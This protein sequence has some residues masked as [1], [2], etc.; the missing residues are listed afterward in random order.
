MRR[1]L[2][3]SACLIGSAVRYDGTDRRFD[4]VAEVLARRYELVA[5]CPEVELGLGVP[6]ETIQ[7]EGDPERPRLFGSITR[8]DL[9]E[10]MTRWAVR[11]AAR[12]RLSNLVGYVWK[13]RSPSCGPREVKHWRGDQRNRSAAGSSFA[14]FAR[15]APS[16]RWRTSES[17]RAPRPRPRSFARST[18][19]RASW[20]LAP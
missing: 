1:P 3:V 19:G 9:T 11:R 15:P 18:S 17:S 12:L 6:R 8:R 5:I 2:G 14:R 4:F 7:L 20:A 10:A 16:C 13:S